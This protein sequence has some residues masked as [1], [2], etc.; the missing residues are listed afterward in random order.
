M[1]ALMRE[2]RRRLRRRPWGGLFPLP[3]TLDEFDSLP[4]GGGTLEPR[5]VDEA[6]VERLDLDQCSKVWCNP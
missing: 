5:W 3:P 1:N 2:R 6:P 4:G